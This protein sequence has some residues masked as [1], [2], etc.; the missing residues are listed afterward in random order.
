MSKIVILFFIIYTSISNSI[1]GVVIEGT[2]FTF[3]ENENHINISIRNSDNINYLIKVDIFDINNEKSLDFHSSPPIFILKK[4]QNNTFVIHYNGNKN[5]KSDVLYKLVVSAIPSSEK[6]DGDISMA[7][8]STFNLIK[9][10][11]D[12]NFD[13]FSS[14]NKIIVTMDIKNNYHIKN[15]TNFVLTVDADFNGISERITLLPQQVKKIKNTCKAL[16]CKLKV[17]IIDDFGYKTN[18]RIKYDFK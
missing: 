5:E 17:F 11:K 12:I 14:N 6:I 8:R 16:N 10:H 3:K 1:A 15:M 2:R 18:A 13:D 7:V 4:K 9:R